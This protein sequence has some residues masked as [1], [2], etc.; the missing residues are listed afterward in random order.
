MNTDF[1]WA[2]VVACLS[3]IA[4]GIAMSAGPAFSSQSKLQAPDGVGGDEFGRSV[5]ISGN[6][7]VV[8]AWRD[9]V[10]QI[11]DQGSAYIYTFNGTSWSFQQKLTA[12]D[13]VSQADFGKSVAIRGN[14]V[15]VGAPTTKVGDNFQ[16]GK[17]Y[18]FTRSGNQWTQVQGI[19][20]NDGAALDH[21]GSDVSLD[22]DSMIIGASED[23]IGANTFQ[24][25]AYVFV[26]SGATWMQQQKIV[27]A[28]SGDSD[29]FGNSVSISGN[30]VVIGARNN[31]GTAGVN[32]G[33]AYVFLRTGTTWTLQ[34][35]LL[36]LVPGGFEQFGF[37]VSLS[38]DTVIVGKRS[39]S[40]VYVFL[41]SG[42]TWTEQARIFPADN[43][44]NTD[45]GFSVSLDGERAAIGSV[46]TIGSKNKQGAVYVFD[47]S[48]TTWTQTEKLLAT[49]GLA[50]DFLGYSVGVSGK[51][52]IG[53]ALLD[54]EGANSAQGAAYV[55]QQPEFQLNLTISLNPINKQVTLT[56][57]AQ[58]GRLYAVKASANLNGFPTTV[59][60]AFDPP[61]D[62]A[63]HSFL[64]PVATRMFYLVEDAGA[65]P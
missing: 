4:S 19:V 44:G 33:A 58:P 50:N 55:F 3:L 65:A 36:P 15:V 51:S 31:N 52:V 34:K 64:K 60:T 14:T 48:G 5:A 38:G 18:V 12:L 30:T 46:S 25:S 26:K 17:V 28:D 2:S 10:G 16:Q 45:F 32:Q 23:T 35:K 1:G 61:G 13:G 57:D 7:A 8:G 37:D 53:G 47:R 59:R 9:D 62:V 27:G 49:D 54:D 56:W 21:F 41:R 42:T 6:T 20:A 43:P 39:S 22:G 11:V 40:P 63:T 29:D 24:G